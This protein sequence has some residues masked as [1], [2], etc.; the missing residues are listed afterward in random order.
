MKTAEQKAM[1]RAQKTARKMVGDGKLPNFDQIRKTK[2]L[3][4]VR[5]PIPK[6]I[7]F[8]GNA[9]FDSSSSESISGSGVNGLKATMQRQMEDGE[10]EVLLVLDGA[11][12]FA[13]SIGIYIH[14]GTKG[15]KK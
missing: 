6:G 12:Q 14:T 2:H 4:G 8:V 7:E 5:M 10:K 15:G 11:F 13:V 9:E 1:D 3:I